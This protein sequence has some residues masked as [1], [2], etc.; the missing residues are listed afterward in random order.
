[1][2][3]EAS[4]RSLHVIEDVETGCRFVIYATKSGS[5]LE[6]QFD[7]EEPWFSQRD[8]A[9]MF[10]VDSDTV[11]DHIKR[12]TDDGELDEAT[13]GR[14]PVVRLEGGRRVTREIQHYGLDAAFYVGYRVN[15]TEG[16]LFRRWATQMLIQTARDAEQ[17]AKGQYKIF[18]A[19]RRAD[20][21]ARALA[22]LNA[23]AKALP[24]ARK[25]KKG[26]AS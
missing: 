3:N 4:D 26:K 12:F 16:K 14:F 1:M 7:G 8:L 18:D 6:L 22:D 20:R 11:G 21:K 13:T 17:H 19:A 23:K 2:A 24:R 5:H 15:S 10:G 9:T 25:K